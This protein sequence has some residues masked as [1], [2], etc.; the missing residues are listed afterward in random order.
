MCKLLE[1]S[2]ESRRF[3]VADIKQKYMENIIDAA[4]KCDYIDRIILFGSACRQDCTEDSDIDLAVFGNQTKYKCLLSGKYRVFL[5]QIY[6]FDQYN[7]TYDFLYFRTGDK[8]DSSIMN[9][10]RSGET[11]YVRQ[12]LEMQLCSKQR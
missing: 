4:K 7:Q 6:S 1:M 11:I 5:E 3:V 9:S 8:N 12:M 10:V 2:I